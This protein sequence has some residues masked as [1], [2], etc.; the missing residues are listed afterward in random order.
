MKFVFLMDPMHTINQH[1]DSTFA[2]MLEAQKRGHTV[3]SAHPQDM[4]VE[5]ERPRAHLSHT[6]VMRGTPHFEFISH[7][8]VYLDEVD[9]VFMRK[10]P[11][12][13]MSYVFSTYILDL[14][15]DRVLVINDPVGIKKANEKMY[16]LNFPQL[17]PRTLVSRDM[18]IL[19]GF[20]D[21]LGGEMIVKP[22]DGNGG[23]GVLMVSRKD[24]NLNSLLEL[25]TQDSKQYVIAQQYIPEVR[26]GDKRIILVNGEPKGAILR[27]PAEGEHRSNMHVG[28]VAVKTELTDRDKEICATIGDSLRR[29]GL[30][31]VGI[32]VIGNYLTEI[33]VTSPTGI[34]ELDA[35]DGLCIE[36][37]IIDHVEHHVRGGKRRLA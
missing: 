30:L 14:L 34:Q 16:T 33:N 25:T 1:K 28:A 35:F 2:L 6:K 15:L 22:W 17:L 24:R 31:F 37:D 26:Q 27:V 21:D 29:D 20:L 36:G 10:D 5:H 12:F 3:Y 7:S 4:W 18:D 23:R 9:A 13:D 11:P 8:D 32:D 19:K